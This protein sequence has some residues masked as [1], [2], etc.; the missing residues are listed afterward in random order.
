VS[1]M[2]RRGE[3][4][5][6]GCF[7]GDDGRKA[8]VSDGVPTMELASFPSVCMIDGG[9]YRSSSVHDGNDHAR[10]CINFAISMCL[11]RRGYARFQQHTV[12][13]DD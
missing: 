10:R 2:P 7:R 4:A 9:T 13:R 11:W 8:A 12:S 5:V 1:P 3:G 6:V